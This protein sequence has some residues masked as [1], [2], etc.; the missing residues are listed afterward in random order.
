[1]VAALAFRLS[2]HVWE[3]L[4][5]QSRSGS[6]NARPT[7]VQSVVFHFCIGHKARI[8]DIALV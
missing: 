7:R 1:M 8:A 3:S 2:D 6:A 4:A 5:R